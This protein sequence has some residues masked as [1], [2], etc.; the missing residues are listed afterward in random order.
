MSFLSFHA[1]VYKHTFDDAVLIYAQRPDATFVADM[2]TWNQKIG[3]WIKKGAKSIAVFDQTK[4]CPVLKNYF[5]IK[6][7][8][9]R[10]ENRFSYP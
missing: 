7:T 3:R 8:T 5:D 4:D 10:Q 9:V 6:D 2:K 1:R